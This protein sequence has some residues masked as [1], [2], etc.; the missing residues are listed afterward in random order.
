MMWLKAGGGAGGRAR[1]RRYGADTDGADHEA[2][3]V[4]QRVG[5]HAAGRSMTAKKTEVV[6][7]A[8]IQIS[9]LAGEEAREGVDGKPGEGGKHDRADDRGLGYESRSQLCMNGNAALSRR[10][11]DDEGATGRNW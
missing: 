5:K 7:T 4:V 1:C 3:L 10:R 8:L 11:E 2:D 9:S 6:I